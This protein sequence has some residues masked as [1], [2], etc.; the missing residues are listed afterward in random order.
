MGRSGGRD[1]KVAKNCAQLLA[2]ILVVFKIRVSLPQRFFL[3][4]IRLKRKM[5]S[6]NTKFY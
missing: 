3:A 4:S 1:N 5:E 2:L 6:A